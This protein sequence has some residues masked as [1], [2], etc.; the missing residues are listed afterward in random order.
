MPKNSK[1]TFEVKL[2]PEKSDDYIARMA[3]DKVFKG[4]IDAT[5]NGQMLSASTEVQGSAGYVAMERVA[6]TLHGCHG[7]FLLQHSGI[8]NKGTSELVVRVVPDSGTGEW[9]DSPPNVYHN[10]RRSSFL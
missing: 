2:I 10:L 6:G 4:D 5:R 9:W 8:M 7:T 1:G 3:I